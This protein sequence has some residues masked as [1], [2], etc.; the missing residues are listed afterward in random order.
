[1]SPGGPRERWLAGGRCGEEDTGGDSETGQ[2]GG[3]S[4][5]RPGNPRMI[6]EGGKRYQCPEL[7]LIVI[8]IY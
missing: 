6:Q 8:R 1:M 2:E 7:R 5:K 4:F 3:E